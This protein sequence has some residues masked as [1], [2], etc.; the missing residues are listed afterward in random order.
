M[1]VVVPDV[2]S[3]EFQPFPVIIFF[4]H[5]DRPLVR[6]LQNSQTLEVERDSLFEEID[7]LKSVVTQW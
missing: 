1:A 4:V 7:E 5:C 2:A 6:D 3:V